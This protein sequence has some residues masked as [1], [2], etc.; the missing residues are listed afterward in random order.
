[1]VFALLRGPQSDEH[2]AREG[3]LQSHSRPRVRGHTRFKTE[4][5][6]FAALAA[7]THQQQMQPDRGIGGREIDA[8]RRVAGRGEGPVERRANVV[9][10]SN[11]A[12]QVLDPTKRSGADASGAKRSRKYTAWRPETVSVSPCSASFSSA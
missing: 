8:N 2:R 1:M 5:R 11:T 9:D 6:A 12:R 3:D 10:L 7:F 4:Q